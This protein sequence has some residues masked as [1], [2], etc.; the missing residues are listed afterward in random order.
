LSKGGK[1]EGLGG[2]RGEN[3]QEEPVLHEPAYHK[4][5]KNEEA[6]PETG[7]PRQ[8]AGYQSRDRQ[9]SGIE[10]QPIWQNKVRS[11]PAKGPKK[12]K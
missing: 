1:T 11:Y 5:D 4:S 9:G 3:T 6:K 7:L 12:I 10:D 8:E 2:L